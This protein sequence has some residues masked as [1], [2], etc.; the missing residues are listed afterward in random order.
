MPQEAEQAAMK[1]GRNA[2]CPCGSGKKY[3]H[4]CLGSVRWEDIPPMSEAHFRNLTV[5]GKNEVF[6]E[7]LADALQIDRLDPGSWSEVKDACTEQAVKRIHASIID[8]WPDEEDLHRVLEVSR[9]EATALYVGSY[10]EELIF[11]GLT[12]HLLYADTILLPDPFSDPRHLR[13]EYNPLENANAFR[14][15]TLKWARIWLLLSPWIAE[16]VVQFIRTPGDFDIELWQACANASVTKFDSNP[17]LK[18]VAE[19]EVSEMTSRLAA[20]ELNLL[21]MPDA[22]L[23]QK[24]TEDEQSACPDGPS[25]IDVQKFV[26]WLWSRRKAHPYFIAD[27]SGTGNML[28]NQLIQLFSGANYEMAK[29][30]ASLTG[31][32]LITDMRSRWEEIKLDRD[33]ERLGQDP[34]QPFAKAFGKLEFQFLNDVPLQT[35][36]EVRKQ[37]FLS[38][39]RAFFRD[40]WRKSVQ[41]DEFSD[42]NAVVLADSLEDEMRKAK[43]EFD[44]IRIEIGRWLTVGALSAGQRIIAPASA[45]YIGAG[46]LAA[47]TVAGGAAVLRGRN[48][49]KTS[50]AAYLLRMKQ[51]E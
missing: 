14:V 31:S 21:K 17:D 23:V 38:S 49:R 3:K 13:P 4:C 19:E 10:E 37:S 50:P 16:G 47:S 12:R 33:E 30:T 26:E 24:F 9:Q 42:T 39:F 41:P 36:L 45:E 27:P 8:L 48:L 43:D 46:L 22:Y 25:E 11:R 15:T 35:A 34:W 7:N 29:L 2:G 44:K 5:R 1:I 40:V 20:N 18:E 51:A 28:N 6:L 32:H